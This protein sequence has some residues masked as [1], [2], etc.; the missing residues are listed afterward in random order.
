MLGSWVSALMIQHRNRPLRKIA[1]SP[2]VCWGGEARAVKLKGASRDITPGS[3]E[4]GSLS[5]CARSVFL[6]RSID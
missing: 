5:H 6:S 1:L 3:N 4:Y 2:C